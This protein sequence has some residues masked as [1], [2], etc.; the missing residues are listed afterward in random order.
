MYRSKDL[1]KKL[2]TD[3]KRLLLTRYHQ[4]IKELP[5]NLYKLVEYDQISDSTLDIIF[6]EQEVYKYSNRLRRDKIK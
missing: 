2:D 4:E 1:W 5:K 6:E 3:G